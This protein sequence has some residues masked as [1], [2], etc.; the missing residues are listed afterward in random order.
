MTTNQTGTQP[1]KQASS[2]ATRTV[3]PRQLVNAA[4]VA[5]HDIAVNGR[6]VVDP[7]GNVVRVSPDSK[8]FDSVREFVQA[9]GYQHNDTSPE[10]LIGDVVANLRLTPVAVTPQL[11]ESEPHVPA[12]VTTTKAAIAR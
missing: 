2:D 9:M 5:M 3:S 7:T 4:M 8:F 6:E 12:A 10:Q 1:A 11:T